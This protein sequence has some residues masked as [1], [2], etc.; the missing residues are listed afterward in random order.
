MNDKETIRQMSLEIDA[1]LVEKE[2]AR[3][4]SKRLEKAHEEIARL[5]GV[6][7]DIVIWAKGSTCEICGVKKMT[8]TDAYD[9]AQQALKEA[10]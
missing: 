5:K 2:T 10:P 9:Y 4:L 8:D 6:L 7:E 3:D 1:L